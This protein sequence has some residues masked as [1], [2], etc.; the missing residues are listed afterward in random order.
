MNE[1]WGAYPSS[2][3]PAPGNWS[4]YGRGPSAGEMLSRYTSQPRQAPSLEGRM[5]DS[6]KDITP[7][8][9][10]MNGA[11]AVFPLRDLSVIYAKAW[12]DN[13][14]TTVRYIPEETVQVQPAPNSVFIPEDFKT[15][16]FGRLDKIEQALMAQ[17]SST[18]PATKSSKKEDIPNG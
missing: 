16:V 8:E 5:I 9:V 17:L 14:I 1:R 18:K 7:D 15:E 10:P 2:P 4:N 13:G 6:P 3:S 11:L 12:T